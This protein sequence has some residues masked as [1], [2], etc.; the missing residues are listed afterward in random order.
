[1]NPAQQLLQ[2]ASNGVG[3]KCYS[4]PFFV[5]DLENLLQLMAGYSVIKKAKIGRAWADTQKHLWQKPQNWKA[6]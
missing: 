4:A 6:N 1:M 2:Q 3:Q 5:P